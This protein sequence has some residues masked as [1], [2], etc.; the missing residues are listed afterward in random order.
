MKHK[1]QYF[2]RC[3]GCSLQHI[4]Y[5]DQLENKK[6]NLASKIKVDP[7]I[8]DVF[9]DEMYFYRNRMDLVF[10]PNGVGFR[11]KGKWWKIVDVESCVISNVALNTQLDEIRHFF[12]NPDSFDL[13]KQTGTFRYAVIR[14]PRFST[15]ISFVLN[16]ESS[17]INEAVEK[18]KEFAMISTAENIIV[19]YVPP[20]TDMSI[21]SDF[22]VVK[23]KDVLME[24]FLGNEFV[25]SVQGFFQNN[26]VMA[27][28][29]QEYV[30]N[31]FD[32]YE[33]SDGILLDLYAGVGTF[34]IVNAEF[35]K[36]V[37]IVES[38][39]ECIDAANENIK[40]NKVMDCNAMVMDAK[41]INKLD[42]ELGITGGSGKL[43]AVVDP[44]RS[45]MHP[46]T[47]QYLNA[48]NPEM[49]VY[50][51]C[52][53]D[54]LGKDLPKFSEYRVNKVA[55]FDLFP[56]TNHSEAIVELVKIN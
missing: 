24:K 37:F 38:V 10:H 5:K 15:S 18:I 43:Y 8:I 2:K 40:L 26:S 33:T 27:E 3:G 30:K 22:F 55:L 19:T 25:F 21:S 13:K 46:K 49:V 35:F 23:G 45:G 11:E 44:P 54:Q 48:F 14:T 28:K 39:K 53:V 42:K 31:L 51:S 7:G 36:K 20:N 52:N 6:N 47:I 9:S 56:Q 50:I 34:G 32:D 29:M 12:T 4:S 1:C 17:K 16:S 41:Q